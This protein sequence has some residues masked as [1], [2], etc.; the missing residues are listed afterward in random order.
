MKMVCDESRISNKHFINDLSFKLNIKQNKIRLPKTSLLP[1]R[2]KVP[3]SQSIGPKNSRISKD[4]IKYLSV[5]IGKTKKL[6]M[7]PILK[8]SYMEGG[9]KK[10]HTG[11]YTFL[12]REYAL[13]SLLCP[14]FKHGKEISG[15]RKCVHHLPFSTLLR[16]M[17]EK[18][19]PNSRN[20]ATYQLI[21]W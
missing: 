19:P 21:I 12:S 13:R 3:C 6:F 16:E 18:Q 8:E 15:L 20:L 5:K 10:A 4:T 7:A 9:G 2:F 11:T 14:E 1:H 17:I